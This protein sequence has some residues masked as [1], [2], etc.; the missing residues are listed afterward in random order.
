MSLRCLRIPALL[1]LAF[2]LF[3][4]AQSL[5]DLAR[6]IRAE[7]QQS[8]VPHAK[9]YTND[10]LA[11]PSRDA[12]A[13]ASTKA[14]D[15]GAQAES[16][17]EGADKGAVSK[18]AVANSDKDRH[19]KELDLQKR[20]QE[21]NQHYLDRIAGL[22]AQISTAQQELARLQR[23]QVESTMQFQSS[24]GT[25]P[26]IYTYAQQQRTFNEQI[27]AQRSLIVSLN[28]QLEDAQESARHAG[29]PHATD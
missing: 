26:S 17:A 4:H 23:D 11:S 24:V 3:A 14:A 28:S 1:I 21:I 6:H 15:Q 2:P 13:D 5:G 18:E 9:V 8:G 7:R 27:E 12:A 22:R 29:V 10:D 25:S 19:S 20:T 16:S